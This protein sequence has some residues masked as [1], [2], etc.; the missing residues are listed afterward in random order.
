MA[1]RATGC[2][3]PAARAVRSPPRPGYGSSPTSPSRRS[4]GCS[5]RCSCPARWTCTPVVHVVNDGGEDTPYDIRAEIGGTS[6]EVA[7]VAG[8]PVVVKEL[9]N[10]FHGTDLEK[11][12]R[13]LGS[14]TELVLA[15]F[16]THMCMTFTAQGAFS[17]GYRPTVVAEATATRPLT[18]PDGT[19]VTAAALQTA[20][21]TTMGDLFGPIAPTVGD[22]GA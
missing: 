13:E 22:L 19:V 5:T 3:S 18:S 11:T 16:M 10:A 12:L 20:A 21:L 9:P 1:R 6:A 8:E 4:A 17:L 7:P 2:S 14:G 15:G